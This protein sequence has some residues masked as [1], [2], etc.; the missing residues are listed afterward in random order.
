MAE[1]VV[2][3][4]TAI[5]EDLYSTLRTQGIFREKL[6]ERTQ[7][8]LAMRFFQERSLSLGQAARLAGMSR[9]QF[10]ELLAENE[11]PVLDFND[12]ELADEFAAVAQLAHQLEKA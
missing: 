9:W 11:I 10:V 12:E 1:V 3:F 2:T 8:L 6:V 7:R 4:E 5:P